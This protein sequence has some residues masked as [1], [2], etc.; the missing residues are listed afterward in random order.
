MKLLSSCGSSYRACRSATPAWN[1]PHSNLAAELFR[2]VNTV[3]CEHV[4]VPSVPSLFHL[5]Q[6]LVNV[7][8]ADLCVPEIQ[9]LSV[10]VHITSLR[11]ARKNSC[12]VLIIEAVTELPPRPVGMGPADFERRMKCPLL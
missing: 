7:C 2:E 8:W 5:S 9:A 4:V 12:H 3:P 10:I 11:Q 6:N 1:I